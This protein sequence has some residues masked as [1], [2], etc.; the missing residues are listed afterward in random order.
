MRSI[1]NIVTGAQ[2]MPR[3]SSSPRL[4]LYESPFKNSRPRHSF[5]N[6]SSVA[7]CIGTLI[8]VYL[9]VFQSSDTEVPQVPPIADFGNAVV[10]SIQMSDH[11]HV[12]DNPNRDSQFLK[13]TVDSV[14][15]AYPTAEIMVHSPPRRTGND[16]FSYCNVSIFEYHSDVFFRKA[17]RK[18]VADMV[19]HGGLFVYAGNVLQRPFQG[20][21]PFVLKYSIKSET[22]KGLDCA[23]CFYYSKH[24][25]NTSAIVYP[26][27]FRSYAMHPFL[28]TLLFRLMTTYP[29]SFDDFVSEFNVATFFMRDRILLLD[30]WLMNPFR[31]DAP[32][33]QQ[34]IASADLV[35]YTSMIRKHFYGVYIP[36]TVN[37][38]PYQANSIMGYITQNL[39]S[40]GLRDRIRGDSK[41]PT[42]MLHPE[43]YIVSQN[44]RLDLWIM[45]TL[46]KSNLELRIRIS[47]VCCIPISGHYE[48]SIRGSVSQ[49]RHATNSMTVADFC[50]S[51]QRESD[52]CEDILE[53]RLMSK[54][55]L[56]ASS[57]A[58]VFAYHIP[59]L[60]TIVT[61][62]YGGAG[63][64]NQLMKSAASFYPSTKV[65]VGYECECPS[66]CG[67]LESRARSSVSISYVPVG[68][69][70]SKGRNIVLS[71]VTTPF[72]YVVDD[73]IVFSRRTCLE[74]LI[75]HLKWTPGASIA[76]S[77]VFTDWFR[78]GYDYAGS[79]RR[80]PLGH[81]KLDKG[82]KGTSQDCRIVEFSNHIFMG[83]TAVFQSELSWDI[84]L[85]M[86]EKIE[87]FYRAKKLG[88]AVLACPDSAVSRQWPTSQSESE[89]S[90]QDRIPAYLTDED[91][92]S[93]LSLAKMNCTRLIVNLRNV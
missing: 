71:R 54:G 44:E 78:L 49:I 19:L 52:D 87:L 48:R 63:F 68:T 65:V 32:F 53:F 46:D 82:S 60:V 74:C 30:E 51:I 83:I 62:S 45:P 42:L 79:F 34:A 50:Y 37:T 76:S 40:V 29:I 1:L 24:W 27:V 41:V 93:N 67:T 10:D 80:S 61:F 22:A 58:H 12:L 89:M 56:I 47:A 31:N 66:C 59:S 36:D 57:Q 84:D 15:M 70:V 8:L 35:Y 3:V 88:H 77:R 69:G 85:K 55:N 26:S 90:L 92:Y 38:P 20:E 4:P 2:R 9:L 6:S 5:A 28:R 13:L 16:W 43:R 91:W 25:G 39:P 73:D 21:Y 11:I 23:D 86:S 17:L 33:I 7:F 18:V 75:H 14:C 72:F 64:V 81:L